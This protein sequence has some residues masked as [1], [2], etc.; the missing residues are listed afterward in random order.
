IRNISNHNANNSRIELLKD[1]YI[2]FNDVT[3]IAIAG[4]SGSGKTYHLIFWLYMLKPIANITI[5][6]P[7]FDAPSR[8][9]ALHDV[10]VIRPESNRSNSDFVASVNDTLNNLLKI[11][12]ERQEVLFSKPSMKFHHEVI[13]IDELL[14][15]T[16][17]TQKQIKD[18]FFGLLGQIALL[19]RATNVHI[20]AVSQ[21]F[22]ANALPT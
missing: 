10:K 19:G 7:K 22:D 1:F 18:A 14:A 16:T 2:D 11:I 20:I 13:V 12:M 6:D 15:L 17:A 5:I 3:H 8:W 21:R 9:A 4:N